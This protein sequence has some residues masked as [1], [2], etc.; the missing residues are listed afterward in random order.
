MKE[1]TKSALIYDHLMD[2]VNYQGWAEFIQS[3]LEKKIKNYQAQVILDASCGTANFYLHFKTDLRFINADLSYPMLKI[4]KTKIPGKEIV[5]QNM[6]HLPFKQKI[7]LILS[8]YDS[9]NYLQNEEEVLSFFEESK[10]VLR[11]NGV[12]IFDIT[13]IYNSKNFFNNN[14]YIG[15][16]QNEN[17]DIPY[18]RS[19]YYDAIG[20]FQHNDIIIYENGKTHVENHKQK[21][22]AISTYKK[23]IRNAGLQLIGAFRDFTFE[24]AEE[25]SE[26]VTFV[27]QNENRN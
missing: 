26:R 21:V 27:V 15:R 18:E 20:H 24:N 10:K 1:Y 25:N 8:L 17:Y 6:L 23:L 9:I 4:A 5:C 11:E 19:S 12:L 3:I 16:L 14:Q 22:F 7:D 2:H 13:T